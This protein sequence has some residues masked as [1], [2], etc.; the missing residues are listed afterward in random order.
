MVMKLIILLFTFLCFQVYA[1]E[2]IPENYKKLLIQLLEINSGTENTRG[3]EDVR[4]VLIPEFEKLGFKT[5]VTPLANNRKLLSFEVEGST[6]KIG[7]IGHLDTVFPPNS[8]FQKAKINGAILNGP[9]AMD[10]KGGI[11]MMLDILQKLSTEQ[12]KSIRVILNDDEETGSVA[13]KDELKKLAQNLQYG[14]VFEPGLAKGQMVTSASGVYWLEIIATG[15]AAHAGTD[16][17]EGLNACVALSKIITEI[18]NLSNTKKNLTINVG[19]I[20]GGLKPNIVCERASA[21]VD[22]RYIEPKVLKETLVKIKKIIT[23]KQGMNPI[24]KTA[25]TIELNTLVNVPSLTKKSS[26][27]LFKRYKETAKKLGLDVSQD[28]A[29]FAS[30]AN[31][32][33]PLELE[34]MVGFGAYGGKSHTEEEFLDMSTYPARLSINVEF[35]KALIEK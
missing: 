23:K 32:L 16:F 30:D 4:R 27:K 9:G 6:P 14:L 5:T 33:S 3:L 34:L 8:P 20:T 18:S 2:F 24:T 22:I 29:S 11:I 7:F 19:S 12:R 15:K 21:K 31:Q 35:V 28:H 25:P 1:E 17:Y 13:S 10:M 26:S